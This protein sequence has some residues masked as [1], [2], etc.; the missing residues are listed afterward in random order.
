MIAGYYTM[1]GGD[2]QVF[3]LDSVRLLQSRHC[4][5][6]KRLKQSPIRQKGIA[7]ASTRGGASAPKAGLAMTDDGLSSDNATALLDS[8]VE[9]LRR[10]TFLAAEGNRI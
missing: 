1:A 5:G 6:A 8:G 7:T 9:E 10:E 3:W 2:C 4:E